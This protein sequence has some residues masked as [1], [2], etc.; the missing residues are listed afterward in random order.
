M[1]QI[2]IYTQPW[3]PYCS[4]AVA[5]L[6]KKGVEFQEIDAPNG[7]PQRKEANARSGRTSVPQIFVDG[8]HLGGCDVLVALGR[9]GKLDPLLMAA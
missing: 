9:A 3:C 7:S 8:R 5:L 6:K 4:Q 2:E 1:A